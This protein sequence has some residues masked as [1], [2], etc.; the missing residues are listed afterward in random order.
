MR[1]RCTLRFRRRRQGSV[2]DDRGI[3]AAHEVPDHPAGD[4]GLEDAPVIREMRTPAV[5][6]TIP[7]AVPV[8]EH[9][10][11]AAKDALSRTEQ[12]SE[13]HRR[14]G[15]YSSRWPPRSTVGYQPVGCPRFSWSSQRWSGAKYSSMP[16]A[17]I[18][19]SPV[20]ASSASGH[21]LRAPI[22]SMVPR[23]SPAG[24]DP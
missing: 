3:P 23:R 21:S 15:G 6:R 17:S 20:T 14:R 18:R 10:V 24:F 9:G 13:E 4:R 12:H 8:D 19:R 16:R 5:L 11:L 2:E 1:G 22:S 7:G